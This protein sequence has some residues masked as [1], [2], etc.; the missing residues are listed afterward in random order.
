MQYSTVLKLKN[1][2]IREG[3]NILIKKKIIGLCGGRTHISEFCLK[4]N[5]SVCNHHR[6]NNNF[7]NTFQRKLVP[8]PDQ[9]WLLKWNNPTQRSLVRGRGISIVC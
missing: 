5:P 2:T 9:P 8:V 4:Y 7:N 1:I 6:N 3:S